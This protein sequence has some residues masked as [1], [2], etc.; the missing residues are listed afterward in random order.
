MLVVQ[1]GI[2]LGDAGL[3]M[4]CLAPLPENRGECSDQYGD[5]MSKGT[6]TKKRGSVGFP[7]RACGDGRKGMGVK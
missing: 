5:V 4:T 3:C 6:Q 2:L 7:L 1:P